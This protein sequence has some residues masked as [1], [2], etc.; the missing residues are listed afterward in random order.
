MLAA[1]SGP[2]AAH[3]HLSFLRSTLSRLK[4]ALSKLSESSQGALVRELSSGSC[5]RA[6]VKELPESSRQRAV[7]EPLSESSHKTSGR[8]PRRVLGPLARRR[9]GDVPDDVWEASQT[10]KTPAPPIKILRKPRQKG[11]LASQNF[12]LGGGGA[13]FAL[14]CDTLVSLKTRFICP[15]SVMFSR[16]ERAKVRF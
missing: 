12:N 5:Q 13:F 7:R 11:W 10:P 4:R 1:G 14:H 3:A 15:T 2:Q 16:P 9:L 6:L 8:R